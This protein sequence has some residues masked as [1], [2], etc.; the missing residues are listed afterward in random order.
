MTTSLSG[1]LGRTERK[2][3]AESCMH[4]IQLEGGVT[5]FGSRTLGLDIS[6][7]AGTVTVEIT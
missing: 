7:H 4:L 6:A 2:Q 5:E 1:I 3:K